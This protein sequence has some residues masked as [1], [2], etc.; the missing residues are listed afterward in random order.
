M[1][2]VLFQKGKA[3]HVNQYIYIQKYPDRIILPI[4]HSR[5][6]ILKQP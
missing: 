4:F 6:I 3:L 5:T 2:K 1:K